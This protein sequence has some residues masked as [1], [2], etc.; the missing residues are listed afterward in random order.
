MAD[1]FADADE[2]FCGRFG[3]TRPVQHVSAETMAAILAALPDLPDLQDI[4]APRDPPPAF[5]PPVVYASGGGAANTAKIAAG[6]GLKTA[7]SAASAPKKRA[8]GR[9]ASAASLKKNLSKRAS[10]PRFGWAGGPPECFFA[11]T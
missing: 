6:L 11:L 1:I 2:A 4:Q 10:S 8:G 9:T 7:F 3:V 5:S